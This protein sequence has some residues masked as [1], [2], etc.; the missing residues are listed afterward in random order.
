MTSWN[1]QGIAHPLIGDTTVWASALSTCRQYHF[2]SV[3]V[4]VCVCVC[5][6]KVIVCVILR[7]VIT[8]CCKWFHRK[9]QDTMTAQVINNHLFDTGAYPGFKD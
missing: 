5:A 8:V 9:T 1:K 7:H 2:S 6:R 3:F 4:C